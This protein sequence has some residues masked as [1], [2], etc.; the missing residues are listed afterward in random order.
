MIVQDESSSNSVNSQTPRGRRNRRAA[1]LP[2]SKDYPEYQKR[3]AVFEALVVGSP[4]SRFENG[5]EKIKVG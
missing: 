2:G 5:G 1:P 4:A 3:K